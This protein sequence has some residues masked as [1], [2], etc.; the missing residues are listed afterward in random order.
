M[1]V[2]PPKD[3]DLAVVVG[4]FLPPHRGHQHLIET[5]CRRSERVEV[6]V[7]WQKSDPIPGDRRGAWL[8]ELCPEAHVRV[9]DDHYDAEDSELWARLTIGWLGRAPDVVFTSEDY[10]P[11]YAAAMG[12]A[13]VSVDRARLAVPCSGTAVRADPY[14]LWDFI[15]A[16]VRGWYAKRVCV[17]GAESTGTTTLAEALAAH[18]HTTWVPEYGREYSAEKQARGDDVWR[19]EEFAAIAQEQNRREEKGARAANRVVICD[20]DSFA[21]NLW[22]RRYVGGTN[23]EVARLAAERRC[24]LYL[25]TGDEIPF[26]QDGLRDGE[27]IRH[28][29]HLWFEQALAGQATPWLLLRGPHAA[30]LAEAATAVRKLFAGS[31]WQPAP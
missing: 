20:T 19:T 5:A 6:I 7:C 29:M 13:H 23:A 10:G 14:A 28:E 31:A 22:H 1:S 25:L 26:V 24:D 15:G 27:H 21:T 11:G 18:F 16:P 3:F 9:I 8:R 4:K 17:L 12:C 2:D 30:R